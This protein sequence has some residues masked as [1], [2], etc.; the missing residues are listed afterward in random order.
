MD[1]YISGVGM[2][3]F[4]RS[5]E[6][7]QKMMAEA[8][9]SAL[10]EAQL[11]RVD[12]IYMGVMNVE[13]FVGDSNFAVLLADTLGLTGIPSTRVETASSTGAGAFE[14]AFYAV[15]SGHMKHVLVLAGEKMTHLPTAKTTRILSEVIDRSERRYGATMPA[16]AAMIA[17]KYAREFNLSLLKLEDILSQVAI[18]NHSNGSLNPYAQFR[19]IITKEDYLKSQMVAYPL[20]LYDCAPITDGASAIILTSQ[21]TP[22][23]VSGIGHATDT[24]AVRHRGSFTSFNSTKEA[25][26]K[27]YTMSQLNPS[28]IQLAEVHDAF[29]LFEIIGTEDLGFFPPGNGWKALEEGITHLR[30]RLPI[31]PSGGLKARGH[32]V[33]AS[34]LAQLVEIIYQLRG[35]AGKERQLEKA[36]IGLAQ[37]IGGLGNNNLVTILERADRKRIVKEGWSPN[38]HPEINASKKSSTPP[39]EGIGILETFTTL[40]ATPEGFRSPLALGFVKTEGGDMVLACNPDYRSPKE[41][42]MGKKV[43]L[44]TREVLYVFEKFTFWNRLKHWFRR[45]SKSP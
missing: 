9:S 37:S 19:K 22:I 27:A 14:A 43:Y 24:A 32:P 16:L 11:E 8:A 30:G 35:E 45:S 21:P 12:A 38:Y 29:T 1:V 26:Q 10:K 20:R 6:P 18:K 15:A 36:E 4:G 44:K 33:G 7:L 39:P 34:G 31:N 41:L 5:K 13:E 2:T 23:K 42:K 28:D 40:Y 3:K 25:A 17:Q